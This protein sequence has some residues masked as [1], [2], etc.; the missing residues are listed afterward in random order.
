[1]STPIKNL[2][3]YAHNRQMHIIE[4]PST[5]MLILLTME[6]VHAEARAV[7]IK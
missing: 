5:Y 2:C 7:E 6:T 3:H 4:V 1:M